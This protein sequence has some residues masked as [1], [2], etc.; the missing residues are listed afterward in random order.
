[1]NSASN[2]IAFGDYLFIEEELKVVML[3]DFFKT[4]PI[5]YEYLKKEYKIVGRASKQSILI[6]GNMDASLT[7][8][9]ERKIKKNPEKKVVVDKSGIHYFNKIE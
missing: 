2:I 7:I 4:L 1:M 3:A 5:K 9:L 6:G 8:I